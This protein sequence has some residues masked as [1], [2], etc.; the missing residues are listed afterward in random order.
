MTA[1]AFPR[2]L[3]SLALTASLA[4]GLVSS[5][6]CGGG[7]AT[8]TPGNKPPPPTKVVP[9]APAAAGTSGGTTGGTTVVDPFASDDGWLEG[10]TEGEQA[11]VGEPEPEGTGTGTGDAPAQTPLYDGPCWVRWNKG[12]ILRFK[13]ADDRSSGWLR[14]DGDNDGKSDVCA[15][16]W[17]KDGHTNKVTVDQ[18]CT[19]STDAIISPVYDDDV[20]IATASYTDKTGTADAK[21]EI[22]L[23]TLPA[24]TGIAPGYPLYAKRD[25]IDLTITKG[26]VRKAT[27]KKPVEGPAVKVT[28]TYDDDGRVT[29]IKEDHGADGS[30]DRQFDYRYDDV[31]NVTGIKL[32]QTERDDAGKKKKTKKSAKLG[33]SC[34]A[35]TPAE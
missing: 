10:E 8:P 31:G 24:F 20:N 9:T 26:L 3:G 7:E 19:K 5:V 12:P 11:T 18:G 23:I 15:R 33:Y 35:P 2:P 34:W 27:V 4:L 16:F 17:T 30:V 32:A 28:L 13:Y 21:H 22:T 25:D 14:I 29:R 1:V 6:A